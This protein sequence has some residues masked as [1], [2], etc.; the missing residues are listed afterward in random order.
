MYAGGDDITDTDAAWRDRLKTELQDTTAVLGVGNA[1]RGDDA[2]G[3]LIARRLQNCPLLQVYDA[4]VCPENILGKVCAQSPSNVII[5][6]AVDSG[7]SPGTVAWFNPEEI[8]GK[9]ASCHAPSLGLFVAFL[10][11]ETGASA[12]VLGIQPASCDFGARLTEPMARAVETLVCA[13]EEAAGGLRKE[14]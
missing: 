10:K 8:D 13:F 7:E 9:F 3:T 2:A 12:S 11:S 6:D 4:G 1:L 5:V 14:Q